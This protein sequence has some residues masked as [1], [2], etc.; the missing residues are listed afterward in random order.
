MSLKTLF[1]SIL[2]VM[3]CIWGAATEGRA[4]PKQQPKA[5]GTLIFGLGKGFANPQPFIG[6]ISTFQFVKEAI[7]EPLLAED[8]QGRI[9]PNL[10]E[11]Y[12][13]SADGTAFTL[14]LRKGVKF[15][16]GKEMKADDVVWSANHVREPKNGAY[17]HSMIKDVKSVEKLDDYTVKF[18]L[19]IPSVAFLSLLSTIQ[20]LPVVPA[21][22]LQPGQIKLEPNTFIPGTGPFIFEQYQPGFDTTLKKFP[23]YWGGPAYVDKIVFRLITDTANRF[24]ALRTGDVQMADRISPLDVE[25]VKKGQVKGIK[26]LADPLGGFKHMIFNYENPLFQKKAMRQAMSY[27]MDK[28]RL[29]DEVFHGAASPAEIMMDPQGIWARAA[30]LPRQKRDLTKAKTLLKAAGYE[31]QDLVLIGHSNEASLHEALQRMLGEAGIKVKVEILEAGVMNDRVIA[32]KYDFY[33]AGGTITSD[34]N[35]T[36]TPEFYTNKTQ[37][38]RH[39]NPKVDQLFDKL[40]AEFDQKK[41]LKIFKDL[42]TTLHD[43]VADVPLF[44]ETRCRAMLEK[45][46]DFGPAKG[47]HEIGSGNYF[48]RVWLRQ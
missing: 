44:Y 48:K 24:N 30:N 38:G 17:G 16:N 34:P 6:T 2:L 43:D 15:H 26:I 4:A 23:D 13:V 3:S 36:M 32:G 46:N 27:A 28:Q 9:V 45:V 12:E 5:G 35:L 25:R 19:N 20:M 18:T 29:I 21:N 7:Y 39:G 41:R 22:S 8:H 10:A 11:K 40:G 37:K 33:I 31:G 47:Y 14:R 1:W 42:A